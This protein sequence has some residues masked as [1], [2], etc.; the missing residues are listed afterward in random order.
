MPLINPELWE[1]VE[2]KGLKLLP[3]GYGITDLRIHWH[4]KV[5]VQADL[6]KVKESFRVAERKKDE[7]LIL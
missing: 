1:W 4:K 3:D 5:P 6:E 7:E 2:S